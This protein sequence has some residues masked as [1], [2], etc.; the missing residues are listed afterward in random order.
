MEQFQNEWTPSYQ[1]IEILNNIE[2]SLKR[3]NSFIAK[4]FY[5]AFKSFSTGENK[6]ALD[7]GAGIGT[8]AEILMT[9]H[10]YEVTCVE[11]DENLSHK[12][13]SKGFSTFSEIDEL[14]LTFEN[15]FTSNV[16]EHIENDL[17]IL[18]K[19]YSKMSSRGILCIYVP[20]FQILFSDLDA[21][22]G[23]VRRYR[24]KDLVNKLESA[25]FEIVQVGY[26]DSLGFFIT[27][28]LKKM[29][30]INLVTKNT[31]SFS[32]YDN[33]VFPIS[34]A[35]DILGF[36]FFLGKNILAIARKEN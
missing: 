24:K 35:L 32:T 29:K 17:E 14:K 25:G 31:K 28:A 33:L 9:K 6:V 5:N 34:R 1:G 26:V 10:G 16:L 21:S 15:V 18:K 11:L 12:L 20:A 3:Y 4:K 8:L 2:G 7:F 13:K 30:L 27:L 23:H 19:I 36:R 22:V